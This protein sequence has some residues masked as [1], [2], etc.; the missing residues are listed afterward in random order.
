MSAPYRPPIGH[1][2]GIGAR[3]G[4]GRSSVVRAFAHGAMGRWIDTFMWW[5]H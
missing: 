1:N 5:T 2:M 3:L 4:A